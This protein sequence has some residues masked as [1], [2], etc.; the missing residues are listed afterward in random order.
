MY[1]GT[2]SLIVSL[3]Q[4]NDVSTAVIMKFF[5]QNLAGG[6]PKDVALRQAK[7]QYIKV[8]RGLAA[9]PAFW[10]PF[11]QLGDSRAIVVKTKGSW[12]PWGVGGSIVLTLIRLGFFM[13]RKEMV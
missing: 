3:W 8:A 9:H 4:V 6:M 12:L 13:R 7:L 5:Y 11:I 1:A 2:P 10:S